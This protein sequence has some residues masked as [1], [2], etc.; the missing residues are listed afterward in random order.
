MYG[1][2]AYVT[3][4]NNKSINDGVIYL[5][6]IVEGANRISFNYDNVS[7]QESE[8][9]RNSM[10]TFYPGWFS[11]GKLGCCY[12]LLLGEANIDIEER[13]IHKTELSATVQDI[14][15]KSN[16]ILRKCGE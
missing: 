9:L 2:G 15:N 6:S 10:K 7:L 3:Y 4:A 12:E 5:G 13:D 16:L 11:S 14:I 1:L 8:A